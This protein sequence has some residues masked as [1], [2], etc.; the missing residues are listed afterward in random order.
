MIIAGIATSVREKEDGIERGYQRS[1]LSTSR[2]TKMTMGDDGEKGK[3]LTWICSVT[4]RSLSSDMDCFGWRLD[5]VIH[6]S[7]RIWFGWVVYCDLY[8]NTMELEEVSVH[9]LTGVTASG[10]VDRPKMIG[11]H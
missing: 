2:G 1:S 9:R 6:F 5:I 10:G 7:K 11:R 3:I 8:T 4:L